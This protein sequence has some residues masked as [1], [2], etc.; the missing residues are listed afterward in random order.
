MA[1]NSVS[2]LLRD[3]NT[4]LFIIK[5]TGYHLCCVCISQKETMS[6]TMVSLSHFLFHRKCLPFHHYS[7]L[8]MNEKIKI[9]IKIYCTSDGIFMIVSFDIVYRRI[10]PG[11]IDK[12]YTHN[13]ANVK[14]VIKE[15]K[16]KQTK[17][18]KRIVMSR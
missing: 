9:E 2:T 1:N 14:Y 8:L 12:I 13:L 6:T 18:S 11:Y 7:T 16:N 17:N 10:L 15:R 3:L 4:N 5:C